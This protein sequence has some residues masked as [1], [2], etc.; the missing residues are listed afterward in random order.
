MPNIGESIPASQ[1]TQGR[2][3]IAVTGT[4]IALSA[5]AVPCRAVIVA[6]HPSNAAQVW[7][8]TAG[9]SAT[10]GSETGMPLQA[11]EKFVM[12]IDDVAKLFANGTAGDVVTWVALQQ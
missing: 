9:V 8:G 6:A 7:V 10:G 3:A 12:E 2:R 4:A 11:N 1:G 5:S